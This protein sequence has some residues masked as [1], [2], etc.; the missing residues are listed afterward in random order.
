MF[1]RS[2]LKCFQKVNETIQ[3]ARINR[4]WKIKK[5]KIYQEHSRERA[6]EIKTQGFI[7]VHP[8]SR[9]TSSPLHHCKDF[10]YKKIKPDQ[11]TENQTLATRKNTLLH[12]E[13]N[14]LK[15]IANQELI[16]NP[17][18]NLENPLL[19]PSASYNLYIT[20]CTNR[21]TNPGN[22]QQNKLQYNERIITVSAKQALLYNKLQK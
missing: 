3:L 7:L 12:A 8:S 10:H 15:P 6:G 16:Q 11:F 18:Y 20:H 1:F 2:Y 14:P 13:N 4:F 19:I 21:I 9:A 22:S 17:L 5:N